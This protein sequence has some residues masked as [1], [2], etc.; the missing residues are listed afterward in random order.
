MEDVKFGG[1]T[2]KKILEI[3]RVINPISVAPLNITAIDLYGLRK[4]YGDKYL[5][6]D[7]ET[8]GL[9]LS[10]HSYV[11]WCGNVNIQIDSCNGN[12]KERIVDLAHHLKKSYLERL[13]TEG[14]RG[15]DIDYVLC[16]HL[17]C[18]HVGWNTRLENGIWVPTFSNAQYLFS[19][20]DYEYCEGQEIDPLHGRA[21]KDSI[22][23]VVKSGQGNL[24]EMDHRM[25]QEI[26]AGIWFEPAGG[27]PQEA[28]SFM[29]R[30]QDS[31]LFFQEMFSIILCRLY[32]LILP[33]VQIMIRRLRLKLGRVYWPVIRIKM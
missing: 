10:T 29:Q 22:L 31:T 18:D 30:I 19:C 13:A 11:I 15:E 12:D 4:W 21:F 25:E 33:F 27:I 23:P 16:T 6:N 3:E 2:I 28:V 26:G 5:T 1:L 9:A 20:V 17:H 32:A 24:V 14:L 8:A 7:L